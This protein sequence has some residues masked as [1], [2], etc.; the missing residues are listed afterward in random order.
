MELRNYIEMFSQY[1]SL[2][3]REKIEKGRTKLFDFNY[4]L[5]DSDYKK[6]FETNFIRNFY[7]REIG[8][9]T[10]E[11]F[12]FQL[13][14]WLQINMPYF[15]KL[16]ESELFKYDP[17]TNMKI[18][19]KQ[20]ISKN[21]NETQERDTSQT[22]QTTGNTESTANQTG[23]N[24]STNSKT[25]DE[26][27]S[28]D[29]FNRHIESDTPDSRLALTANDGEGVI[30]YASKI[31]EDTENNTQNSTSDA[32]GSSHSETSENQTATASTDVNGTASANDDLTISANET[33][34]FVEIKVGKAG[35]NSYPKLVSEYRDSLL[36]IERK[37]FNEMQELFMLVY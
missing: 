6:Q 13:E 11:L 24:D 23:T 8:F 29:D 2:S 30:Q 32:N 34:D 1:E 37:I 28:T 26:T 27:R 9:E 5:F 25:V 12:K 16:F 10:E 7:M 14:T 19:T 17:L 15:N 4:P 3:I 36:R 20:D 21:K 18:E 33:E 35:I 22:T 31:T